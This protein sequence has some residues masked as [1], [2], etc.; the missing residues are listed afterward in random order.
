MSARSKIIEITVK[1]TGEVMIETKGFSG[2]DCRDATRTL[3]QALGC[4]AAERLTAEFYQ[5][6][7]ASQ[8]QSQTS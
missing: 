4:P 1:P 3:E 2:A 7:L 8:T 6:Q 5:C